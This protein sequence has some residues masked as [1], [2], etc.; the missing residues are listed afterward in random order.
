M[1][2]SPSQNDFLDA[3]CIFQRVIFQNNHICFFAL[4]Q[5]AHQ[6]VNPQ[7]LSWD[8]GYSPVKNIFL[9]SELIELVQA[10]EEMHLFVDRRLLFFFFSFSSIFFLL[11]LLFLLSLLAC[12]LLLLLQGLL[13]LVQGPF[14]MF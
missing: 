4:L 8:N 9:D 1:D 2:K 12:F 14:S 10:I 3:G 13:G 11:F 6:I 7:K 5:A